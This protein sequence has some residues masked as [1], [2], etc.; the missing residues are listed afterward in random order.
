M[1][2]GR[3]DITGGWGYRA[4]RSYC[5]SDAVGCRR[6]LRP[7]PGRGGSRRDQGRAACRRP[8]AWCA[9]ATGLTA[10]VATA[11]ALLD[12]RATGRGQLVDVGLFEAMAA[13]HQWSLVLYTHQGVVK[14]RAGNRH[15]ES[16]HPL[17]LQPVRD[18]S[19]CI[20]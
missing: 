20:A 5:R 12:A 1:Y 8:A 2:H 15:A 17:G 10:A 4:R 19:I 11:A 9:Y 3:D 13:L 16:Y 14:R 18:G 6:L 7:G